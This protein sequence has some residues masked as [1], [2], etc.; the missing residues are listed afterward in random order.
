MVSSYHCLYETDENAME[1]FVIASNCV[2]H[3]DLTIHRR[4]YG[5]KH[6]DRTVSFK[7]EGTAFRSK[8]PLSNNTT[9]R[10]DFKPWSINRPLAFK[11][12]GWVKPAGDM[13]LRTTTQIEF[14]K[15]VLT[16]PPSA[17]LF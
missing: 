14:D 2:I 4:D 6:A 16:S 9:N 5:P 1:T 17:S 3:L 13:D 7:P 10:N 8:D 15:Y 12:D 11:P